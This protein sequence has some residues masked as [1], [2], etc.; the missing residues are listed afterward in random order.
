MLASLRM[1]IRHSEHIRLTIGER[2]ISYLVCIVLL[3]AILRLVK[4]YFTLL[5]L[6]K[7]HR[8]VIYRLKGYN[9]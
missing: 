1:Y 6:H 4:T 8:D 3:Y 7:G 2:L 5:S 9:V